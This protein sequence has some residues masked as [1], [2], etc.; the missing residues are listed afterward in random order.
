MISDE[1]KHEVDSYMQSQADR[2]LAHQAG[3][4]SSS[5]N[6]RSGVSQGLLPPVRK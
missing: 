1:F 2:L 4:A 6:T 3:I 5:Y